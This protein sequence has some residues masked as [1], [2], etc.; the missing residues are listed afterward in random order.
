L[1]I[2]FAALG[3]MLAAAG[4]Y[5]VMRYWV[6]S[7]TGE[8]GIRVALGAQPVQVVGLVLGRACAATG[9]G[10]AGGLAGSLALRKVIAAQLIGTRAA[11][12]LILTVVTLVLFATAILAAWAPARRAARVDPAEALRA[13]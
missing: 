8:I 4:V 5:G 9:I 12:P 1:L 11:D 10:V 3:L 2:L 13:E 7:R 6:G